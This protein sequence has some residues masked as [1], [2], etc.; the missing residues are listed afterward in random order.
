MK[1]L[2]MCSFVLAFLL[3]GQS[4]T[5]QA[6]V[7]TC[8]ND[9]TGFIMSFQVDKTAKSITHLTS[10]SP[11]TKQKFTLN[12]KL[13]V[14]YFSDDIAITNNLSNEGKTLNL[15]VFNLANLTIS[16]SGHFLNRKEKPNSQLFE[17]T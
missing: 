2:G 16:Q 7:L 17:C 4:A 5:A 12:S 14:L 10:M 13:F 8:V 11:K 3:F 1:L 15:M 6:Q 9:E